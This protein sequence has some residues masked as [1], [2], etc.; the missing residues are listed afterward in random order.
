MILMNLLKEKK[1]NNR[2]NKDSMAI[3]EVNMDRKL[4]YCEEEKIKELLMY[5]K[6]VKVENDTLYLDNGVE[7]EVLPK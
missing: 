1:Q 4:Y 7:L 6:I 3:L 5:R 2:Q